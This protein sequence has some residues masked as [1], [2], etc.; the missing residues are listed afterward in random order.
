MESEF[1]GRIIGVKV[2]MLYFGLNL[3]TCIY[4]HDDSS[5]RRSAFDVASTGT[6]HILGR[7]E[8]FLLKR[9]S[10]LNASVGLI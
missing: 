3:A 10:P 5:K 8:N 4:L 1:K 7:L 9:K 6:T 2:Q